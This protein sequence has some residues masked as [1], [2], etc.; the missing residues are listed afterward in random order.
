MILRESRAFLFETSPQLVISQGISLILPFHITII[1]TFSE[2]ASQTVHQ[3]ENP[4]FLVEFLRLQ[5]D[6]N[7]LS[8]EAQ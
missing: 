1:C 6:Q 2:F 5:P 4:E 7:C 8:K 3:P